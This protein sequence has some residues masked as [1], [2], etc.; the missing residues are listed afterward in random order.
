MVG[1]DIT[2]RCTKFDYSNQRYGW[3]P[4]K[5]KWFTLPDHALFRVFRDV[6]SSFAT[7]NLP[8]KFEVSIFAHYEDMK[9]D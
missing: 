6:F 9:G 2:Y 3:C 8:S 1:L 7:I 5:F 4:P